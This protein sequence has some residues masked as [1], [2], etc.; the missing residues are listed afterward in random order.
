M[1]DV[2]RKTKALKTNA[3]VLRVVHEWL[4]S[5]KVM[6]GLAIRVTRQTYHIIVTTGTK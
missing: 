5:Q 4:T 3:V 1:F 6:L 2:K